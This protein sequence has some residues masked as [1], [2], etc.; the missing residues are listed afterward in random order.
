MCHRAWLPNTCTDV[1]DDNPWRCKC[2]RIRSVPQISHVYTFLRNMAQKL[3][4]MYKTRRIQKFFH[5]QLPKFCISQCRRFTWH[6][7]KNP[8]AQ[9]AVLFA[10]GHQWQMTRPDASQKLPWYFI[11]VN[12]DIM[13][14][15]FSKILTIDTPY[16]ARESKVWFMLCCCD[17]NIVYNKCI[18]TYCIEL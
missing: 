14:S 9:Q 1:N 3:M 11:I 13:Q 17:C 12:D 8:L 7:W 5:A 4:Y 18:V 15:I 2:Q 16:L 10:L 6:L